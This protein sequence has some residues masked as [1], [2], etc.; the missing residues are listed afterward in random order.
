MAGSKHIVQLIKTFGPCS[1]AYGMLHTEG[2]CVVRG[3]LGL[4]QRL[5]WRIDAQVHFSEDLAFSF[6]KIGDNILDLKRNMI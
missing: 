4:V 5:V 1:Q 3:A 6:K 2:I